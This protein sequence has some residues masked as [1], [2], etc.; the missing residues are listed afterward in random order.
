M[1]EPLFV[2][3]RKSRRSGDAQA[4]VEVA[5]NV[6]HHLLGVRDTKARSAGT[7][8]FSGLDWQAFVAGVKAGSF[9][10]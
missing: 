8:V 2:D 3:W 1:A 4:C 9:V 7:L 5:S 6:E 10:R